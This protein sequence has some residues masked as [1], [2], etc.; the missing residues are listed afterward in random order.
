MYQAN[1]NPILDADGNIS[2]YEPTKIHYVLKEDRTDD[3]TI[4]ATSS[5]NTQLNENLLVN[6]G[7][8]FRNLKS[9]NYQKLL[10][11]LGGAYFEDN[12][13]FYTGNQAQ[14]DLN[15]P[16][17]Q[18]LEGDAYGY[19]YNYVANTLDVFSQFKFSYDK[20]D[21]YLA[22]SFCS[23]NYQREGLYKN[24]IYET[25]S[26]GKSENLQ[27]ENFGFK[28]GLTYKLSGKRLLTFNGAHLTRAPTI[29]SSF[30]N[31]RL[32][33]LIAG[34]LQSENINSLD[35]TYV[36]RSPKLKSRLTAYYATI[37][38]AT[39]TSFFYA[40]GIFDNGAGYTNTNGFGSQTLTQMDT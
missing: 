33:N 9:H 12:D 11:L 8:S 7:G 6:A 4:V 19:N 31:S 24:G 2:G 14:S 27:F 36:F 18:V 13:G 35:A 1:Q 5:V 22:Q 25:I 32:N 28:G 37:K 29:R 40:E 39:K 20:I 38:D 15:N 17:R 3:K 23:T 21:F 34:G 26:F 16:N 10:D 30:P